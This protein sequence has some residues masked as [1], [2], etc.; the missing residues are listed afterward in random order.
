MKE[1]AKI[2]RRAVPFFL[3]CAFA[4]LFITPAS[5]FLFG[6][7]GGDETAV[8]AFSKNAVSNEAI[9]FEA[10][11][12]AA[13]PAVDS[14]IITS[15]PDS[16][17]GV[18]K[19]ASQDVQTGYVVSMSAIE[20]LKFYPSAADETTTSFT[21]LPISG[22][23]TGT[24]PVTVTL[25]L[26][27]KENSAPVARNLELK[28]Y[29]N[30]AVTGSFSAI[31]PD[32]DTLTYQIVEKPARGE[33]ILADDGTAAFVYK[34]YENKTGKDSFTYTA[35][36]SV[37]N[38]S[39]SAIVNIKI[40]KARTS[41]TYSDMEDNPAH[42]A[43][44]R[45]AEMEVFTGEAL[46]DQYFFHPDTQV[47]RGSFVV[48]ALTAAGIT[49]LSQVSATGFADDGTIP[50]WMRPY[51]ATALKSGIIKGVFDDEG[52]IAFSADA[53]ITF[54]EAAVILNR[55]MGFTDVTP[56]AVYTDEAMIPAWAYQ[57]AYNLEST[58]VI[59]AD[60]TG[61]LNLTR[62]V[63]RGDAAEMITAALDVVEARETSGGL[64]SWFK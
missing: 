22:G 61:S 31:D 64:L 17:T 33:V 37:G 24:D 42:A 48:M 44:I 14:I 40:D 12:F 55:A 23:V 36:D 38:V 3:L 20:G 60:R 19:F 8:S 2:A 50:S 54:A 25:H 30:I 4:V 28:T 5:A 29:K 43:A 45:L 41:V 53:P 57:A 13:K 10:G 46:G 35:V 6:F 7:G 51:V 52:E 63:T 56:A 21:F 16:E 39:E 32:G 1:I 15:L 59:I 27:T 62:L 34:P 49:D 58:G 18:L 9:T 47:T 11:D 26:L